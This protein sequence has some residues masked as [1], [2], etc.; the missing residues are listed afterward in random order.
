MKVQRDLRITTTLGTSKYW[1]L[2]TGGRCSEVHDVN[3]EILA[4]KQCLLWT[5]GR[6]SEVNN[7]MQ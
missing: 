3:L 7:R 5:G 2:L 6:Y 1:S 4:E